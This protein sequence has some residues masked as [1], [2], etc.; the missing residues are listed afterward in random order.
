[1]FSHADWR[2]SRIRSNRSVLARDLRFDILMPTEEFLRCEAE[3][4]YGGITLVQL[5]RPRS[6]LERLLAG[7]QS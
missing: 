6:A 5:D 4:R 7:I 3:F 1:M 2:H